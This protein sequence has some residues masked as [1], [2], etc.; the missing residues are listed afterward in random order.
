M[1]KRHYA[2][3]TASFEAVRKDGIISAV[4][5]EHV[6]LLRSPLNA[7]SCSLTGLWSAFDKFDPSIFVASRFF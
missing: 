2:P 3:A 4:N 5:Y 1:T 6:R 7:R